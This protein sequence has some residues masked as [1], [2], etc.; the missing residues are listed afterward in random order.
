MRPLLIFSLLVCCACTAPRKAHNTQQ[1][2]RPRLAPI[3]LA[4]A[5]GAAYGVHETVVHHPHLIPGAWNKQWW[6]GT[7]SWRNKYRNGDPDM[8]PKFPLSTTALVWTTDAKHLFG[9][10]HRATLFGAG[11]TLTLGEKRP[12]WHYLADAGLSFAAFSTGFHG[13]YTIGFK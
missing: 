2:Y 3:G 10:V 13:V 12:V 11:V 6:D 9:S 8:G 4:L 1:P 7:V 5:S